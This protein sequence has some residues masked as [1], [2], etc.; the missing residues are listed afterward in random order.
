MF[1][2]QKVIAVILL[3]IITA[4]LPFIIISHLFFSLMYIPILSK[5]NFFFVIKSIYIIELGLVLWY[6]L[7]GGRKEVTSILENNLSEETLSNEE[8][9][10]NNPEIFVPEQ[11]KEIIQPKNKTIKK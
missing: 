10:Q 9:Y 11:F 6:F 1:S 5:L 8:N 3:Y 7:G 4:V 2:S